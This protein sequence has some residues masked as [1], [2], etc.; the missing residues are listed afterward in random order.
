[1]SVKIRV[2]WVDAIYGSQAMHAVHRVDTYD[3]GIAVETPLRP[4]NAQYARVIVEPSKAVYVKAC[5]PGD[6][7]VTETTG[8]RITDGGTFVFASA[9]EVLSLIKATW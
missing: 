4:A 2:E 7:A 6:P 1:M 5:N 8:Y 3:T 9:H